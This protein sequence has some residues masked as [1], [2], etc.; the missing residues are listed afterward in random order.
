MNLLNISGI[1]DL[2]WK[3]Q[4][5]FISS[6]QQPGRRHSRHPRRR[7]HRQRHQRFPLPGLG[8]SALNRGISH[9][10]LA[11][12]VGQYNQTYGGKPGPVPGQVF[13]TVTPARSY[14]FG[15]SFNSQD[16]RLTK[17]FTYRER[18][19]LEIFVE[20]FNVFNIA[21]LGGYSNNLLDPNFGQATSRA[22]NIFGTGGPRAFQVGGRFTF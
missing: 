2:P 11:D 20:G 19:K 12:L 21:N 5:S 1:V 13:P 16:V 3:F 7:P 10:D 8:G 15:R 4:A 14:S 6:Y 18:Y 17:L 9:Q 22:G